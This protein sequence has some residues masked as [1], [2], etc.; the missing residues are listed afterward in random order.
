[1]KQRRPIVMGKLKSFNT[2]IK[3]KREATQSGRYYRPE[4][5]EIYKNTPNPLK[6]SWTNIASIEA[7]P[8]LSNW[9]KDKGRWADIDGPTSAIIGTIVHDGADIMNKGQEITTDW[10][11]D[12]L[13]NYHDIRWR[14]VYPNKWEAVELIKKMLWSYQLWYDEHKP[15]ILATEIMMWHEDMPYAGTADLILNIHS[16]RQKQDVIMLADLKTGSEQPDK[17]FVQCMAYALLLEK[18]YDIQVGAIGAL[19]CNGKWKDDPKP[20]RLKVK[21]IRNKAGELTKEAHHYVNRVTK[22]Y[23]LW[24]SLQTTEQPKLKQ[25]LPN[26]FSLNINKGTK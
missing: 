9:F 22:V 18:I 10:I 19:Y 7:S 25:K 16:P 13:D 3:V 2:H 4:T 26:K 15:E 21:M 8:G 1:M 20:G 6:P 12:K 23:E 24:L 5:L 17:H 11:L 14:L